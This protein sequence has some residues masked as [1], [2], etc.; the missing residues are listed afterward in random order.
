MREQIVVIV[1]HDQYIA[2]LFKRYIE[3]HGYR[4]VIAPYSLK[5][6][7]RLK[8]LKPRLF[9]VG[10]GNKQVNEF[11]LIQAIRQMVDN[12]AQVVLAS[13]MEPDHTYRRQAEQHGVETIICQ[14]FS[15]TKLYT[16]LY[17]LL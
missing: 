9:L 14:P 6:L 7:H 5:S 11:D 10:R 4:A 12:D 13:P 16:N 17:R 3:R 2:T 15:L 8:H 1:E